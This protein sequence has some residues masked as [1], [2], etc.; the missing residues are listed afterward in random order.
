MEKTKTL[1]FTKILCGLFLVATILSFFI[2][3]KKIDSPVSFKFLVG[4]AFFAFII[5]IYIP[6]ITIMN[7]RKLTW[8]QIRKSIFTF[9]TL[10]ILFSALNFT[11]DY[12]SK[13]SEIDFPIILSTSLGL[14]FSIAFIDILF[15]KEK[16]KRK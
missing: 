7:A 16:M 15:L 4:Y 13:E 1:L 11:F 10:F 14:S 9:I 2:I 12:L 3:F 5:V 8:I 6:F